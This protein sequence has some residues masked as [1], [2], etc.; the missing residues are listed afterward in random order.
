VSAAAGKRRPEGARLD[1]DYEDMKS[2]FAVGKAA[3]M[4][5]WSFRKEL[6]EFAPIVNRLRVLKWQREN[7]EKRRAKANRYAAKAANAERG[8][9]LARKRRAD[10]RRAEGQVFTCQLE[11]CGAQFCRVPG[12]RGMGLHP[13]FCRPGHYATWY[14]R[15]KR[16]RAA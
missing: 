12:V 2:G 13:R 3:A 14:S 1:L 5:E 16:A 10:R 11:G 7:P 9:M 6:R 4:A 15:Q 8:L